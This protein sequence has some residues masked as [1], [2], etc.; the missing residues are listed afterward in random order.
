M[1]SEDHYL[2]SYKVEGQ[3]QKSHVFARKCEEGEFNGEIQLVVTIVRYFYP[4]ENIEKR[5]KNHIEEI[6]G[7]IALPIFKEDNNGKVFRSEEEYFKAGR[8]D[9]EKCCW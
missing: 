8:F 5:P 1:F 6:Y 4:L 3:D 7:V 2:F 9:D